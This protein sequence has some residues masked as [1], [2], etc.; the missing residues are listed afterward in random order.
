MLI[1][2]ILRYKYT[3]WILAGILVFLL[4]WAGCQCNTYKNNQ[5]LPASIELDTVYVSIK[6]SGG[7][8][9][10][11]T[12]STAK[13][14]FKPEKPDTIF[15]PGGDSIIYHPDYATIEDCKTENENLYRILSTQN[16]YDW[17]IPI[18]KDGH[19]YGKIHLLD[20]IAG[21]ELAGRKWNADFDSIPVITKTIT[22]EKKSRGHLIL[23]IHDYGTLEEPFTL[24]GG[25]LKYRGK[26]GGEVGV[27]A[28]YVVSLK[29][30]LYGLE[31]SWVIF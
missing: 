2:K 3:G 27:G 18:R 4:T 22:Q 20:T 15:L 31:K 25:S 8:V 29:R 16:Y 28:S 10:V 14:T 1:L 6:D 19:T 13:S 30:M 11:K 7:V 5:C 17:T 21:N 24:F 26:K 12:G 9:P 23:A